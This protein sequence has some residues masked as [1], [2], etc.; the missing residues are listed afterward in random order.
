[1][2]K[3]RKG[4]A[5]WLRG[6]RP[7]LNGKA[8]KIF[9]C[10]TMLF[11]TLS[12]TVFRNG[13]IGADSYTLEQLQNAMATD[14][15]FM[16]LSGLATGFQL[17]GGLSVPVFAFLLVEGFENTENFGKYLLS[18]LIFGAVSEV[19]YDW[20][21]Y[22]K[23]YSFEGQNVMFTYTV[24]LIMLYGM[25]LMREKYVRPD[26]FCILIGLAGVLW[27]SLLRTS[28]GLVTVLLCI[29]YYML[30][31]RRGLS[32]VIGCVISLLYITAPLSGYALWGYTGE[33]GK[34]KHKYLFYIL[35]PLHLLVLG[36][37]AEYLV[38]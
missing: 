26:L 30:R 9:G 36:A 5:G 1:M 11:Y 4:F 29:V 34:I 24:C 2:A 15:G 20:A 16:R 31:D 35:Y 25:R 23:L 33:R 6:L 28:F 10:V 12:M 22:G 18:M 3:E 37:I 32:I 27:V 14:P 13:L 38:K 17:I 21:M 19:P 7:S 8:L